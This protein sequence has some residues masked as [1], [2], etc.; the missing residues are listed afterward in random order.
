MQRYNLLRVLSEDLPDK[1]KLHTSKSVTD[2]NHGD[3]GV[4]V[5]CADGSSYSGDIVVGTDGVHSIVKTL[6]LQR[7]ESLSPGT[8]KKDQNSVSAEYNCIYGMGTQVKGNLE[9]GWYYRTY[10]QDHSTMIFVGDGGILYWF[11][12]T[13]LDKRYYG[14]EIPKYTLAD[15]EVAAQAFFDIKLPHSTTYEDL[16]KTRT[17]VNMTSIEEAQ[18]EHWTSGRFVCIGDSIHKQT[19]NFGAGANS[20]I[21]SAA[22]LTNSLATLKAQPSF[23]EVT[24]A[25]HSFYEKRHMR[26]NLICDVSN[27]MTRLEAFATPLHK[28]AAVYVIPFS[29]DYFTDLTCDAMV[30]AELLNTLPAPSRSLKA[31]MPWDTEVGVGKHEKIWVRMLRALPLLLLIIV[32]QWTI[33][34]TIEQIEPALTAGVSSGQLDLGDGQVVPLVTSFFRV[35]FV[36]N[37]L[38]TLVAVFTPALLPFDQISRLQVAA[39]GADLVPLQIIW[40]VESVRRGNFLTAVFFL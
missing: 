37:I 1:T 32:A 9:V 22:S 40:L 13:K 4:T 26:A 28:F 6:M 27:E 10:A 18:N 20:A 23:G 24:D 2:I 14:A 25:L 38:S 39:F 19:I 34:P 16:W 21:E 35:R 11:L 30:G 29:G 17:M 3:N 5:Q 12:F 7:I 31:T 33:G 36:D 15:A 8:T